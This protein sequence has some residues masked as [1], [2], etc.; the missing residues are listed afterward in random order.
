MSEEP[1]DTAELHSQLE[2][3]RE[4]VE[5]AQHGHDP[6][7]APHK[8]HPWT[9]QL[10]LSTALIAVLAAVSSLQSGASE[11]AALLE[12]NEAIMAQAKA[13]DQWSYFQ[14]KSTKAAIYAAQAEGIDRPEVAQKL[15]A[16]SEKYKEEQADIEKE[17]R[18]LEAETDEHGK[19]GEELLH[20]HH[21]F[22]LAVTIFQVAIALSAIAALTKR[23]PLWFGSLLVGIAG[24][25]FFLKGFGLLGS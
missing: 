25:V 9:L 21:R 17:A 1:L 5:H 8:S 6:H 16:K 7:H 10:S 23:K 14:A 11:N 3:T 20:H 12:K 19:V 2:E 18:K 15:L 4:H 22:A 24:I 13:T